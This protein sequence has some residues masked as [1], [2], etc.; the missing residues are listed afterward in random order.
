MMHLNNV[1]LKTIVSV[2]WLSFMKM[3]DDS[4]TLWANTV[5]EWLSS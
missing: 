2:E 4:E 1:G 3:Y 5:N